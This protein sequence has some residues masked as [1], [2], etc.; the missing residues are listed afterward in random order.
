[1]PEGLQEFD[2][3]TVLKYR[4]GA[5]FRYHVM[6]SFEEPDEPT[7]LDKMIAYSATLAELNGEKYEELWIKTCPIFPTR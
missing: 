1:M 3:I 2:S 4:L 5:S 7:R 6:D